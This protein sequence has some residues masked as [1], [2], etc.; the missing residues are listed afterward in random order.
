VIIKKN[1]AAGRFVMAS[2]RMRCLQEPR[3]SSP[4]SLRTSE[5]IADSLAVDALFHELV[6]YPADSES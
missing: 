1:F 6:K 4:S 2:F 3:S 5:W